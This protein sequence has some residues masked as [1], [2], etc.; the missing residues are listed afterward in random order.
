M[1]V[2]LA[3][4]GQACGAVL[5]DG[6]AVTL[7]GYA[8]TVNGEV[9]T[10]GDVMMA[11]QPLN[12]QAQ[13]SLTG[14]ALETRLAENYRRALDLLV[15]NALMREEIKR[16]MADKP[17]L[18]LPDRVI[19]DQIA[20]M[21]RERFDGN[22]DLFL[23]ALTRDG[24]TVADFRKQT[25]ER[26][27]IMRMQRDE[28][29]DRVFVPPSA[30]REEYKRR[31]VEF[32][33]PAEIRLRAIVLQKGMGADEQAVKRAQAD[34]IH[35]RLVAG[36]N[37]AAI[38]S[39]VSE[40]PKASQGGDLGW[41]KTADLRKEL[42]TAVAGLELGGF[43]PVIDTGAEYYIVQLEGRKTE[44]AKPFAEVRADLER[45]LRRIEEEKLRREWMERL[46]N[47]HIVRLLQSE[48][49]D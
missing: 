26:L 31:L 45:D 2:G 34:K 21:V 22:R 6:G 40:G 32:R 4:A 20:M 33:T 44:G 5:S 27:N 18:E 28:V 24:L 13:I 16:R 46:R 15:E 19:E 39:E 30:V 7:D 1:A 12:Q 25:R 47:R 8:A 29:Y 48:P 42:A 3:C 17:D 10:L 49:P 43:T 23:A 36:E 37:F 41:M 14:P 11:A 38:A 35:A 9:I